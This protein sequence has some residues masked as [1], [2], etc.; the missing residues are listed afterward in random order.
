MFDGQQA[1]FEPGTGSGVRIWDFDHESIRRFHS[2][3]SSDVCVPRSCARNTM[4]APFKGPPLSLLGRVSLPLA[5]P[6]LI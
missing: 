1:G 2:A 3:K 5:L 4:S 6:N